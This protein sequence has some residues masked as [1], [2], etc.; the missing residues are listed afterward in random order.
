MRGG[1]CLR[2][3]YNCPLGIDS[4]RGLMSKLQAL[5]VAVGPVSPGWG[6]WHWV[7]ESLLDGLKPEWA[8]A[9]FEVGEFPDADVVVVVK[10]PPSGYWAE[11]VARRAAL[12]YC[13]IDHYASAEAIAADAS[14]LRFCSQVV[15][16]SP[17]LVP[18]FSPYAS[19]DSLDHP[20][21]YV[22]PLR[23]S[24]SVGTRFLWV[25][26]WS[27]L[28]PLVDWVNAHP[29]SGPLD[30][31]TNRSDSPSPFEFGFRTDR[32]VTIHEWTPAKHIELT[33]TCRAALD[34][35][36]DDFRSRHK[37]PA[38]AF[39]LVA[40][41]VPLALA[42]GH[43]AIEALAARGLSVPSPLDA[44]RWLSESYS[45]ETHSVARRMR[46]DLGADR[47]AARARDLVKRAYLHR[48]SF[49]QG[50]TPGLDPRSR[51][52][53]VRDEY[54]S[55]RDLAVQGDRDGSRSRLTALDADGVPDEF[56]ALAINDLAVLAV[57]DGG[58]P[59]LARFRAA[60]ARDPNCGPARAN[61]SCLSEERGRWS[62]TPPDRR[63]RRIAVVSLLFNWPSTGGGNVHST[64]L[65]KF[66]SMA[67]YDVRHFYARY[68]P[69]G[70]GRVTDPTP[71]PAVPIDFKPAEWTSEG[72]C[73]GFGRAIESFDPEWVVLTDS[74][75]MKPV[76][77]RAAG[78]RKYVLRLQALECL[79]PLNNV[80]LLPG[81]DGRPQQ[82]HR[83]Q[84]AT[85]DV[86]NRCVKD[87][88][89]TSG[90]LHRAERD[91][92]GVGTD[93]YRETLARA[94]AEAAS[95]FV[96]NPLTA[97]MVEPHAPSVQVVT[98][99][100]DPARFPW[101]APKDGL[102]PRTPGAVRILFAG[103][104]REWM[105]GFHVLREAAAQVWAARKDFEVVA[106]DDPPDAPFEPWERFIGWQSQADL[107]RH[108][109]AA[110]VVVVP[111]VAQEALGRTAVEA[112]A[113]GR[114]VVASRIGGLPFT[115]TDGAT[116]LLCHPGDPE[117]LA[118]KLIRLLDDPVLR[119]RLGTAG[120][121]RFEEHYAWPA[122]I[123][124]HYLPLFG[125]PLPRTQPE[126]S[127]PADA[128]PVD[129]RSSQPVLGCVIAVRDRPADLL[130]RTLQTY[131]WQTCAALDRVLL[132]YGSDAEHAA[133]YR[134]LGT[135]FGWRY[136]RVEPEPPQWHLADA[137]NRAVAALDPRVTVVFKSDADVLLGPEVL[138]TA[139]ARA[140]DSFCQFEYL[141][142]PRDT[143]CPD[144]FRDPEQLRNLRQ[145]LG[146]DWASAGRGL[147]A[148][149]LDWFRQVGG[150][151]RVFRSWGYEDLDL[152]S[153]AE[154]SI[155][156][157]EIDRHEATLLHQWHPPAPDAGPA[158]ENR[159]Y[160]E[161]MKTESVVRND[162]R[163]DVAIP[164]LAASSRTAP[165]IPGQ[166]KVL[167]VTRSMNEDL[168][169][170]SGEFLQFDGSG[171][172]H[173]VRLTH[174]DA[175]GYFRLLADL[176]A[177]WVVNLDEDAFLLDP[178]ALLALLRHMEEQGYA[179][180]GMP[181]GGVVPIRHHNPVACNAFFNVFDMRQIR[182]LW[183]DWD[184]VT[185]LRHAPAFEAVVPAWARRG[186][187]AFDDFEPY[188][189]LFY[190]IVKAGRR[191]LYL[192]AE[193]WR[194]GT[195]TLVRSPGG[196]PLLL[197]AWYA[198]N[199]ERD[200]STR[201]RFA[202][203]ASFARDYQA[204]QSSAIECPAGREAVEAVLARTLV[205]V[206][207]YDRFENVEAWLTAWQKTDRGK[208]RLAVIH[209]SDAS[210][211]PHPP[212]WRSSGP[213]CY[214]P[215]ANTGYDIG[216]FQDV[217]EGRF[218]SVLPAWEYLIWCTDDFIPLQPS[219]LTRFA[220]R[221]ID[222]RVGLVAGRYGYWPGDWSGKAADQHCR[223]VGF[224]IRRDVARRLTFPA[225]P[226]ATRDQCHQFEHRDNHLMHQV[227]SLGYRVVSIDD[228][229]GRLM[230]D[231][232]ND[233]GPDRWA[234][235]A[236]HFG[237][238]GR[239][240]LPSSAAA[241][242]LPEAIAGTRP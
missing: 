97:A 152:R 13:P 27:N 180:C 157:V 59:D 222:P 93:A 234:T 66:L 103:L 204:R 47:V 45:A 205:A 140:T 196:H 110:D 90:D 151:D 4:G 62:Y 182:P 195:T 223:T 122:I 233:P 100:M 75:N 211:G 201:R 174:T 136:V 79:C 216:A 162:G 18:H 187:H 203:A 210:F 109:Y 14:W 85:V 236:A 184:A 186:E 54:L 225:S 69:W 217:A 224:L 73:A 165:L 106:T 158:E 155:G 212:A 221:A 149:P 51:T 83:H 228:T 172:T 30:V 7:G 6:S 31:L 114:P 131:A 135:E 209:N 178:P 81:S 150:F 124:R 132:D 142:I 168:Y 128:I 206:V 173:R 12:V 235:Y 9:S 96:V 50:A 192:D 197:H 176:D 104:T 241:S 123:T 139:V 71:H 164:T 167:I 240:F 133:D 98:A 145:R 65:A 237:A 24:R 37:P 74:W 19:T 166:W 70:L 143:P 193:T 171:P 49:P 87:L 46:E 108:L 82:C 99:G 118:A 63:A 43:P 213:D 77:T 58:P 214:V 220:E 56:R 33:S 198:R 175:A 68:A 194:D 91:L 32:D 94:F 147:F 22:A 226:V 21:K 1:G 36:G 10:H 2:S 183:A 20:L 64:E 80:R 111:T 231:R 159:V 117:D 119:D 129:D 189:G 101:P 26:V 134:R 230:W 154:R 163:L 208:A 156:V 92:A 76:L 137:Y 112:M 48:A 202:E 161:R 116:G 25:G 121:S 95:V 185:R 44:S 88:G 188:Y 125:E 138:E 42:P 181:D 86:C 160:F 35:K 72:I 84:L 107:P 29:L 61:L 227:R 242:V 105:K 153:R 219:F 141:T 8:T 199:W 5:S 120:R 113:A 115:V 191:I 179:A 229:E 127:D 53:R 102:P 190:A 146:K 57:A 28:P 55:A 16:H 177:D 23:D 17:S 215:R 170:L 78:G 89:P 148:C 52:L 144:A 239:A 41:G 218:D 232:G 11:R 200:E 238:D 169:H 130:T 207:V 39:D 38:K 3:F 34:V 67:G 60:L 40:S 15:V 126:R